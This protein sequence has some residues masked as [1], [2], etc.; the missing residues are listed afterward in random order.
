[1]VDT[2]LGR[3]I[4]TADQIPEDVLWVRAVRSRY[5]HALVKRIDTAGA[6]RTP[7]VVA[8]LT[9][10]DI[11]GHN[12]SYALLPDRPFLATSEVRCLSDPLALVVAEDE[13]A[14]A[15]GVDEIEVEYEPLPAVTDI[16]T[17]IKPGSPKLSKRGNVL[18]HYK[19]RK[20][21]V[22]KGFAESD[23]IVESSYTTPVQDA[24]PIETECAFAVPR[25]DGHIVVTGTI[26]NPFHARNIVS[27]IL[28][29]APEK[30]DVVVPII[31]GTF[32]AKS[33]ESSLDVSAMAA[34]AALKTG[35]AAAALYKRDESALGH[36]R[37]HPSLIKWKIGATRDGILKA[38][39][40]VFYFDTGA[41]ASSGP[42]VLS[43]GLVHATGPY[44]IPNVKV[45][46]YLV[47]TNN[48]T[49]GA[50]RGFGNP[51]VLFAAESH[52]DVLAEKLGIDPLELRLRNVLR[53]G[54][55]TATGQVLVEPVS[56]QEC[57][58][59]VADALGRKMGEY[60]T[61]GPFRRGRGI[62]AV[63]HGNSLG[64]EG[65]DK[66]TA[67]VALRPDGTFRVRVGFTEYGSWSTTNI[68]KIAAKYLGVSPCMVIMERV[69]T[70]RVPDSGGPFASRST[71][72][73]GNAVKLAAT[74]LRKRIETIAASQGRTIGSENDLVEFAKT[75][76][77]EEI[78]EEAEFMLPACDFDGKKGYGVPYL[79]YTYGAV[80]VELDVNKE[81][82]A[83]RLNR[84]VAAFDVGNAI[85]RDSVVSQIEGAVTQGI[86]F[87][88]TEDFVMGKH[89]IITADLANYLVP[90]S[91][92]VPPIEVIVV[93]NPSTGTPLGTRS[94]GEPPIEG[95]GPAIANAVRDAI[96]VRV[97]SLPITAQ[98]VLQSLKGWQ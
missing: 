47:Y 56:L 64:I 7:G 1:L 67:V 78:S 80:G 48:L 30:V 92:D 96:G 14:A 12:L 59:K 35:R 55:K 87:G 41:Y 29:L 3:P 51:Q 31:G 52:I 54:S 73:G 28:W 69:E 21:D 61:Q 63:Y 85:D 22:L 70:D 36:S 98:K 72:M 39:E 23:V 62:A 66:T 44:E 77:E 26:Q 81:T 18:R 74:K 79:Q 6:L 91:I 8:V 5:A 43:R 58:L 65:L 71:L 24:V 19:V 75:G 60:S 68:G 97:C 53:T 86:G 13:G 34:L 2:V 16:L 82:G 84:V 50:F 27:D 42:L 76:I 88:L 33:D 15:R 94:I 49:A 95:P 89:R 17:A 93:E 4:Y 9:A 20:G 90:T 10:K 25:A 40:I 37:R 83:L 11:P 32:G 46:G 38:A 57:L 45:D